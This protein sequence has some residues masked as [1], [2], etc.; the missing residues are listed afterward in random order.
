MKCCK[1][2][3]RRL[4]PDGAP[5]RRYCEHQSC[6]RER[7][8]SRKRKSRGSQWVIARFESNRNADGE[9]REYS[10]V[11]LDLDRERA[12]EPGSF[13]DRQQ[14]WLDGRARFWL[15]NGPELAV[16]ARI[17]AAIAEDRAMLAAASSDRVALG[18]P[19]RSPNVPPKA[20]EV[21]DEDAA[22]DLVDDLERE[23]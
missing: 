4:P 19:V 6:K 12:S 7:T 20:L 17:A 15:Q 22:P 3:R 18:I 9:L 8:R 5:Q 21:E 11:D 10:V 14:T 23:A 13:A 16:P 1:N 2:C